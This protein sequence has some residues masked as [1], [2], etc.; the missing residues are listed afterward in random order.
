MIMVFLTITT[1]NITTIDKYINTTT[2]L[3]ITY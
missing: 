1:Y 3:F 2:K